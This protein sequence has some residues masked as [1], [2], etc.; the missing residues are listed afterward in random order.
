MALI[1]FPELFLMHRLQ[2]TLLLISQSNIAAILNENTEELE[3]RLS[4][5]REKLGVRVERVGKK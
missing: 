5:K 4:V 1:Y 2:T 3:T